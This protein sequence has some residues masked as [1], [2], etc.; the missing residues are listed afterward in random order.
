MLGALV[1]SLRPASASCKAT[2][3]AV[4]G[5]RSLIPEDENGLG[6]FKW[7]KDSIEKLEMYDKTK[8]LTLYP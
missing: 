2:C 1:V 8:E 6:I 7:F 4:Q 3:E 5:H